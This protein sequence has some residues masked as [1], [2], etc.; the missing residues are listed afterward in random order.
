MLYV[1]AMVSLRRIVRRRSMFSIDSLTSVELGIVSKWSELVRNFVQRKPTSS[2][3]PS[4]PP[5][6]IRSPS[7]TGRSASMI[8]PPMKLLMSAWLPKPTPIAS[9]P[10]RIVK[11]VRSMFTVRIACS[12]TPIS[13]Q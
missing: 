8:R 4:V 5:N 6:L 11:A 1:T 9:A 12:T 13:M 3:M 2:T 7:R 10:P